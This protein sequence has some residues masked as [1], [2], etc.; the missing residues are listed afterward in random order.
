[1]VRIPLVPSIDI[2]LNSP[3]GAVGSR[4]KLSTTSLLDLLACPS[5]RRLRRS[6]RPIHFSF[7][8]ML[9]LAARRPLRTPSPFTTPSSL[10]LDVQTGRALT[11]ISPSPAFCFAPTTKTVSWEKLHSSIQMVAFSRRYGTLAHPRSSRTPTTTGRSLSA[12]TGFTLP[13]SVKH[14]NRRL[15]LPLSLLRAKS[16]LPSVKLV[17]SGVRRAAVPAPVTAASL[18]TSA[19]R[20]SRGTGPSSGTAGSPAPA[21]AESAAASRPTPLARSMI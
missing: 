1:M 2:R 21:Q 6:C 18:A 19:E 5:T 7:Y 14:H 11:S 17:L 3:A 4:P 16:H 8:A 10:L 20:L 13:R 15:L 9:S 12:R